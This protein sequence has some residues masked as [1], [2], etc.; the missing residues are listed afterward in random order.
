MKYMSKY[1]AEL[2]ESEGVIKQNDVDVCRYGL[3]VFL[4]SFVEILTIL[5]VSALLNNF[6]E[7]VLFFAGF[8]P[9][10]VYAG[11]YHANTKLRCYMVSVLVYGLFSVVLIV[12]PLYYYTYVNLISCVFSLIMVWKY[13]PIIHSRRRI[14]TTEKKRYK[15]I[16]VGIAVFQAVI[17]VAMTMCTKNN[18]FVFSFSIGQGMAVLSMLAA[19]IKNK[20]DL[21]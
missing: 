18:I 1:V 5:V 21:A 10:R 8:V 4:S 9:L 16:S 6:I 11:G 14:N 3:E 2:L 7:T 20:V 12:L 17:I 15:K 13:A 19:I